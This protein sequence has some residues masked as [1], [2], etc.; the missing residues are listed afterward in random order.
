MVFGYRKK[1]MSGAK[2]GFCY[3]KRWF[4]S[5]MRFPYRVDVT[6]LRYRPRDCSRATRPAVVTRSE[7][8]LPAGCG[9]SNSIPRQHNLSRQRYPR[10]NASPAPI[11][12]S[13]TANPRHRH[14]LTL[15]KRYDTATPSPY[16]KLSPTQTS[17][18]A[19]PS[20]RRTPSPRR[21]PSRLTPHPR[22]PYSASTNSMSSRL[23]FSAGNIS[24]PWMCGCV[25]VI[26][27]GSARKT[28]AASW[29]NNVCA[30]L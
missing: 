27:L 1:A 28:D 18:N 2:I 15:P 20:R 23:Y 13:A 14:T 19:T 22:N 17:P 3:W 9:C 25:A 11:Q 29:A 26:R 7:Q 10:R 12:T 16:S 30:C 4:S 5:V 8:D 24:R 21:T 6:A